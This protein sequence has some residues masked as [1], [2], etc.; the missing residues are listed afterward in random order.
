MPPL[1]STWLAVQNGQLALAE[2]C[3]TITTSNNCAASLE[4]WSVAHHLLIEAVRCK[5]VPAS[6][7][8][9]DLNAYWHRV[10][11]QHCAKLAMGR[12][13]IDFV[14]ARFEEA[15]N[16]DVIA[17]GQ[18]EILINTIGIRR[19][20]GADNHFIVHAIYQLFMRQAEMDVRLRKVLH[21]QRVQEVSA[22]VGAVFV[23]NPV[24]GAISANVIGDGA[25]ILNN[26]Q[27]CGLAESVL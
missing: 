15:Q 20:M 8:F 21:Y 9:D 17:N 10:L 12:K 5:E 16:A 22:L 3:R 1:R 26:M 24:G 2:A 6:R 25:S 27:V 19:D 23:C 7:K 18:I 14:T 13:C 4:E 11:Y